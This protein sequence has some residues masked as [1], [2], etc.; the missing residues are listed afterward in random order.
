MPSFI[1]VGYVGQILGRALLKG[2]AAPKRP[3]LNRV[4]VS[5]IVVVIEFAT[6]DDISNSETINL[7]KNYL[8]LKK[9]SEKT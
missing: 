8:E 4:N 7:L 9:N 5:E 2:S 1:I 3:I 6:I